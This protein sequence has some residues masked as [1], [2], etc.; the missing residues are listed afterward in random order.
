MKY[1]ESLKDKFGLE[2]E[3]DPYEFL[4]KIQLELE[5]KKLTH[6]QRFALEELK[7][8]LQEDLGQTP[9][10]LEGE[11]E[12]E[13]L[14]ESEDSMELTPAEQQYF[15][16]QQMQ[17]NAFSPDIR[18]INLPNFCQNEE[19]YEDVK[20]GFMPGFN[21]QKHTIIKG[22]KQ[23]EIIDSMKPQYYFNA[24]NKSNVPSKLYI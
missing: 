11:G 2:G 13:Y 18:N 4:H 20:E 1:I 3:I 6:K 10:E 21:P 15:L 22:F 23:A 16:Y 9:I 19:D 7:R 24:K 14:D 17:H 5:S 12:I 8:G